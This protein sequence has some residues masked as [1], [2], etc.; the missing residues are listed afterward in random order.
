[1]PDTVFTNVYAMPINGFRGNAKWVQ[2]TNSNTAAQAA[3]Q[4]QNALI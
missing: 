1:M 3:T 2:L 4:L